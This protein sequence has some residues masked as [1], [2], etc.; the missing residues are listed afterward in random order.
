MPRGISKE[1]AKLDGWL[2]EVAPSDAPRKW[3]SHE[4]AR[5]EEFRKKYLAELSSNKETVRRLAETGKKCRNVTLLYAAK[6]ELRNN[7]VVLLEAL[8]KI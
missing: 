4:P 8:K 2:K 1:K 7:A 3:F 5:W 6:D